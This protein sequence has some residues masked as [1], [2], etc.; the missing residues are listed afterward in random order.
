MDLGDLIWFLL[1]LFWLFSG[2][3]SRLAR[4]IRSRPKPA[5]RAPRTA[6]RPGVAQ[7]AAERPAPPPVPPA[8]PATEPS[9]PQDALGRLFKQLGIDLELAPETPVP[10]EHQRTASEHRRTASETRRSAG[11]HDH[12]P[13]WHDRTASEVRR[14]ASEVTRVASEHRPTAGEH[15]RGDVPAP[16][17]MPAAGPP[18]RL[19]PGFAGGLRAELTRGRAALAR[20]VVLGEILGPPVGLKPPGRDRISG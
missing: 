14:T 7:T 20:A 1:I 3:L 4:A 6:P 15:V 16:G 9:S 19:V 12:T 18:A 11:E 8:H 10:A 5:P 17:V 13:G 2:L